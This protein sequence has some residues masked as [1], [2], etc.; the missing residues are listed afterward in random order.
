MV[1]KKMNIHIYVF[2]FLEKW[3]EDDKF[4]CFSYEGMNVSGT[5]FFFF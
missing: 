4:L 5:N 3:D 2:G 1:M